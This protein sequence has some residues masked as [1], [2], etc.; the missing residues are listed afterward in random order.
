MRGRALPASR[1]KRLGN[2]VGEKVDGGK[3][4]LAVDLDQP[5]LTPLD[6]NM[7]GLDG[8]ETHRRWKMQ[9]ARS[10]LPLIIV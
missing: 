1:L 9:P 10:G 2:V 3:R 4:R 6:A 5:G 7:P 8:G